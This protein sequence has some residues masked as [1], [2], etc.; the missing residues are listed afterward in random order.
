MVYKKILD[1][2]NDDLRTLRE[3]TRFDVFGWVLLCTGD[4]F[5]QHLWGAL[6][7]RVGFAFQ[8]CRNF[9]FNFNEIQQSFNKNEFI[10]GTKPAYERHCLDIA[11]DQ[12]KANLRRTYEIK[13]KS[14]FFAL[15]D[16]INQ[17]PQDVTYT[18]LKDVV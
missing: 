16:V 13:R 2:I 6:K 1:L 15:S 9:L 14:P 4:T 3:D 17:F 8:K 18:L 12:A 11:N 5:C 7:E 10:I